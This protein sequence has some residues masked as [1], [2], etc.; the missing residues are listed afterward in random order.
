MAARIVLT[1][2]TSADVA[3]SPPGVPALFTIVLAMISTCGV[4]TPPA[5]IAPRISMAPA[6]PVAV[7]PLSVLLR[8]VA[9][10]AVRRPAPV[11]AVLPL[12]VLLRIC[13]VLEE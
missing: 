7:L 4:P 9:G 11:V 2:F 3:A 5:P 10:P 1:I 13:D 12:S 6:P 8:T